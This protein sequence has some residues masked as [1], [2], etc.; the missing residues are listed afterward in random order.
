MG[1][2]ILYALTLICIFVVGCDTEKLIGGE[3]DKHGCLSA[4]GY[5]WCESKQRCLRVWEEGCSS[6]ETAG[7]RECLTD[8]DCVRG[9]CSGTICQ[10]KDAKPIFTTCEWLPEYACYK[11]IDCSCIDGKCRWGITEEFD[12][13]VS[14][15]R[16]SDVEIF[17]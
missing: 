1:K 11:K 8:D 9:G 5:T 6:T 14:G 4:A 16:E 13:C 10:S 2:H 3:K 17:K 7:E 15:A 12:D